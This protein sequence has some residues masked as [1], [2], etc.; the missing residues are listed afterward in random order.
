MVKHVE[1][2]VDDEKI[3]DEMTCRPGQ[4]LQVSVDYNLVQ[5]K[6]DF[7]AGYVENYDVATMQVE[8]LM[9]TGENS[10][11]AVTTAWLSAI[12][13]GMADDADAEVN[14]S[15]ARP[16]VKSKSLAAA[17]LEGGSA[18]GE[19]Q[20]P[21]EVGRYELRVTLCPM[22]FPSRDTQKKYPL[23]R[24]VLEVKEP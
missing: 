5:K 14:G 10:E 22:T 20:A 8:T 4:T 19:I 2:W 7:A 15:K 23:L 12:Q 6:K 18:E 21:T 13:S 16:K 9:A 17:G 1:L 24:T 11:R 3:G